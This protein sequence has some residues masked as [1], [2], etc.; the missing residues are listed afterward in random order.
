MMDKNNFAFQN[1]EMFHFLSDSL[2][3]LSVCITKTIDKDAIKTIQLAA[4][5]ALRAYQ[6]TSG[7]L[8]DSI[9]LKALN[10]VVNSLSQMRETIASLYSKEYFEKLRINLEPF[11]CI[12]DR[13]YDT[14]ERVEPVIFEENSDHI[15]LNENPLLTKIKQKAPLSFSD[16]I[17][18]LGLFLN[19]LM[20]LLGFFPDTQLEKLQQ[21][22]SEIISNQRQI[23]E[24]AEKRNQQSEELEKLE[25]SV[26]LLQ[27]AIN[28]L[29]EEI[30]A[31]CEQRENATDF[32]DLNVEAQQQNALDQKSN[33]QND[34]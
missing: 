19:I 29:H 32:S 24:I 22:N 12:E 14:W 33:A 34:E 16:K 1:P 15:C 23:I 21:Q 30:Q 5:E 17:S 28:A 27:D 4:E 20:V 9:D 10:G 6:Q 13:L 26:Y 18:V 8:M 11:S 2:Q 31:F 3:Q 7:I 25:K